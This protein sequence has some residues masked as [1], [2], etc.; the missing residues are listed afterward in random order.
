MIEPGDFT[1]ILGL[2]QVNG[3][4]PLVSLFYE[5]KRG[6]FIPYE[7]EGLIH[8][9][10]NYSTECNLAILYDHLMNYI[11]HFNGAKKK[12]ANNEINDTL[13]L[14][15]ISFVIKAKPVFVENTFKPGD[16]WLMFEEKGGI[17]VNPILYSVM[18]NEIVEILL[19]LIDLEPP[20]Y[21]FVEEPE[22]HI[23]LAYQILLLLVMLSLVQHGYKFIISTQSDLMASFL[24]DLV[25]YN[26]SKEKIEEVLKK[27]L[28]IDPLPP[29]IERVIEEA[30]K[31][32][33]ESKLKVYYFEDGNIKE[34]PVRELSY[35]VPTITKEV[36]DV[37]VDLETEMMFTD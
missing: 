23:H 5:Y 16:G 30:T 10:E 17:K 27:I 11:Q 31:T 2:P 8:V 15:I 25:R 29:F 19:P 14:D 7:R 21:V 32:V 33:R 4:P 22:A 37:I 24:G 6:L 20:I 1:L 28:K 26:I 12:L 13:I 9:T 3:I 35:R 34:F 18:A 36:V